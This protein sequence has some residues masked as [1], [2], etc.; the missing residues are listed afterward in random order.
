M[1]AIPQ[2]AGMTPPETLPHH[3][4]MTETNAGITERNNFG[5]T[6]REEGQKTGRKGS[7]E[8]N[9]GKIRDGMKNT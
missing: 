4:H 2:G 5:D 8:K 6:R 9:E 7:K 3:Q 1:K